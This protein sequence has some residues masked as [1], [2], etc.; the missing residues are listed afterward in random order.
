MTASSVEGRPPPV[1]PTDRGSSGLRSP[2]VAAALIVAAASAGT[3]IGAYIFQYVVEIPPCPLCLEQRIPHYIAV[4]LGLAVAVAAAKGAPRWLVTAGLAALTLALLTTAGI[5]LYHAG[6][7]WK[8]WAGPADCSGPIT[9]FGEAGSLL[10]Q[11]Q[12]ATVVRCDEVLFRF[13]GL[14]LAGYNAVV[15]LILAGLSGWALVRTLR[16]PARTAAAPGVSQ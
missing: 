9:S 11:M 5:G 14:S 12:Q 4:P 3:L 8:L 10:Q 1:A 16:C 7:E 13:L 2:A 6:V 15:S